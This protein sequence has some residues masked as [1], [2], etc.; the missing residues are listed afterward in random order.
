MNLFCCF[1]G[2]DPESESYEVL[3]G[4]YGEL[5][6]QISSLVM[7]EH[8]YY[9]GLSGST[10]EGLVLERQALKH[11]VYVELIE[12]NLEEELL[13]P[14]YQPEFYLFCADVM[15]QNGMPVA[16]E[17][18]YNLKKSCKK[19]PGEQAIEIVKCL[20][21]ACGNKEKEKIELGVEFISCD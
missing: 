4:P 11:K 14:R 15:Y 10:L 18:I 21:H 17:I 9:L 3:E 12:G 8:Y 6:A 2:S 13:S 19:I 1:C 16:K 5:E 7:D 20:E